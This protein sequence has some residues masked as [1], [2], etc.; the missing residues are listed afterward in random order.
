M[1]LRTVRLGLVESVDD[2]DVLAC[3][4]FG[5]ELLR[6]GDPDIPLFYRSAV[7]PFQARVVLGVGVVLPDEH[8]AVVSASHGGYPAHVAIVRQI[9]AQGG[10]DESALQCPAVWPLARGAR[11]LQMRRGVARP[12]RV[13]HNCSGKHAGMLRACVAAGWPT[14]TYLDPDHPLQRAILDLVREVAEIDPTPLGI[15]GCGAPT[16]RGSVRGLARAFAILSADDR[17]ARVARAV[18]RFPA[19]VSDN[20]RADGRLAMWW[21]GPVK[22][23]A[24]GLIGLSRHGIGLAAKSRSGRSEAAVAAVIE[25]ARQLGLLSQAMEEELA[26]V[27]RP[28]VFGGGRVVGNMLV[29]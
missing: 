11:A 3:D 20:V 26:D 29:G 12:R 7:K 23:G 6:S 25:A 9:L 21:G 22:V 18:A 28:P 1:Q 27:A 24:E 5:R 14:D 17:F 13:F 8:I 16:L 2:V 15:D 19:L 10:L 4:R